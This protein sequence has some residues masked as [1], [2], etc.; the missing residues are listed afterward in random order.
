VNLVTTAAEKLSSLVEYNSKKRKNKIVSMP[1][2]LVLAG[3]G[4]SAY[5]F[6]YKDGSHIKALKVFFPEFQEIAKKEADIYQMLSGSKYYP[7]LYETGD[8]YLVIDYIEG[9]TFFDCLMKGIPISEDL[10]YEVDEA[11]DEARNKGLNPS[12]IHLRN[13]IMTK[14]KK[15]RVIDV[16]R[17]TQTTSDTQWD[18]LKKAYF[19]LYKHP[20]FPKKIPRIWLEIIAFLYKKLWFPRSKKK[21]KACG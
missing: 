3:K 2:E 4:R 5:V 9:Y 13:L 7:K 20:L 15:L 17:F 11:L 10:I 8:S 14:D 12:D 19:K 1:P 18:D 6:K 21:K 16:A